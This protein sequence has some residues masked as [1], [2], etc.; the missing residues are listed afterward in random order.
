MNRWRLWFGPALLAALIVGSW[1]AAVSLGLVPGYLL[2]SPGEVARAFHDLVAV[3]GL[4]HQYLLTL[5]RA[6]VGFG[7]GAALGIL[8]STVAS[9]SEALL[10][11]IYPFAALAAATPAVALIPILIIWLGVGEALPVAAVFICSFAPIFYNTVS[12]A[13]S[14]DPEV[15]SVARTLG[16][17]RLKV[18][19]TIILPQSLPAI[20]SALKMEAAMAWRTAFVAEMLA[21]SSGIGYYMLV[22]QTS[23]RVDY[24]IALI[25]VL[26][27]S[28]Y[29][30]QHLFELLEKRL[31][32]KWGYVGSVG[33]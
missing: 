17:G 13:R 16:A 15:V 25:A 30:L 5:F 9:L 31:L 4:P 19:T 22:A 23:F 7:L 24:L 33:A 29:G 3:E 14:V 26:A 21:M 11:A 2:P 32:A 10:S 18:F 28:S 27:L 6:L 8:L 20:L 12:A 1:Q